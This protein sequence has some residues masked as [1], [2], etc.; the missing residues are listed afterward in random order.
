MKKS[1]K[2]T[3][4]E[5][6]RARTA[7]SAYSARRSSKPVRSVTPMANVLITA[8]DSKRVFILHQ[9]S[10]VTGSM[11]N[12]NYTVIDG[13]PHKIKDGHYVP[14]KSTFECPPEL[15]YGM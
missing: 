6:K 2:I 11:S 3:A 14:L 10:D 12:P 9:K 1:I 13:V 8:Q 4:A 7:T 15:L 5:S